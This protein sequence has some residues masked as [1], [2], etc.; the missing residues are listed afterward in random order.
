MDLFDK[1]KVLCWVM[2]S[3]EN[4]YMKALHVRE[5]WGMRCNS[6]FFM[7]DKEDERFPA[8]GL[9]VSEGREHLTAKTMQAFQYIHDY[10]LHDADW[11]MKCDDDTYVIMENLRFFLLTKNPEKAVFYGQHFSGSEVRQGFVSGGAGYVVSREA[12]R[13]FGN[14]EPGVCAEDTPSG[15]DVEFARCMERLHVRVGD[16]RDR[17]GRSRFH[18]LQPE[19]HLTGMYRPWY[20]RRDKYGAAYVSHVITN[21]HCHLLIYGFICIKIYAD[22]C[23]SWNR[24]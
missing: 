14:R 12:L 21:Y 10:H 17:Y 19:L 23:F 9:N 1:V 24:P 7:S 6:I 11:F 22:I 13:R 20:R 3:S 2:T 16:S 18:C 8:V 15:E 4:L 5:T